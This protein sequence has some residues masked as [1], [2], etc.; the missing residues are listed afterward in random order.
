[1]VIKKGWI[2]GSNLIGNSNWVCMQMVP[3]KDRQ[4]TSKSLNNCKGCFIKFVEGFI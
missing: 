3:I 1:M 4:A 2:V